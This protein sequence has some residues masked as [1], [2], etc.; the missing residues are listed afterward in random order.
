MKIKHILFVCT[1]LLVAAC[2][3]NEDPAPVV[4][5]PGD[6]SGTV[7][8]IYE[9]VPF[10]TEGVSVSFAPSA[11]GSTA[12]ITIYKIRFVPKMPVTIDVTIPGVKLTVAGEKILLSCD[13]VV[14]LAM[15]G[16]FPAYTVTGLTGTLEGDD[17]EFSLNFGSYPTSFDGDRK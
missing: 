17:L 11:D 10:D 5:V 3:K 1:L 15:G 6:Y 7:S 2:S 13:N 14:P 12:D 9:G 8:V 4:P 16:E